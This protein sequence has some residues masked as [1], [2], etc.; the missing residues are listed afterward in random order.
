M[1]DAIATLFLEASTAKLEKMEDVLTTCV[2]KLSDAQVWE[3]RAEHEN[4]VGNLIL[5]LC[6]NMRQWILH[7]IGGQPDVRTRDA[8]FAENGTMTGAELLERF[9][10][11]VAEVKAV[12]ASLPAARL[13]ERI[14]PQN[15]EVSVLEAVYQVVSHVEQHVGQVI[16]LTKQ[17]LQRDLDLTIPRKR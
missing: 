17:M 15:R 11:T 4:A 5:H 3:K 10:S 9:H 7:G 1:S 8:E 14:N 2:G 6:G 12:I 13:A 16:L